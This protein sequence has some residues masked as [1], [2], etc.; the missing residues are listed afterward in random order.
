MMQ[1]RMGV[2]VTVKFLN[3]A[4]RVVRVMT[5]AVLVFEWFVP[6]CVLVS[7]RHMQPRA[8]PHQCSSDQ[9][10]GCQVIA[11]HKEGNGRSHERS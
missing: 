10:L 7:F 4:M 9:Q 6:V 1:C 11:Q 8:K 5:M 3:L 2:E